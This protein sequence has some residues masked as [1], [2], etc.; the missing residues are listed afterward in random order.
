LHAF[1]FSMT[2][3]YSPPFRTG[4]ALLLIAGALLATVLMSTATA[5]AGRPGFM[6]FVVAP[7]HMRAEIKSTPIHKRPNRPLHFYGN[8]VRRQYYRG[9]PNARPAASLQKYTLIR[10]R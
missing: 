2:A 9:N 5:E 4:F 3:T 6:P 7:Y 1:V 8:T 10:G